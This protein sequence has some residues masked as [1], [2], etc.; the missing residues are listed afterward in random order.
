MT[1][2]DPLVREFGQALRALRQ[3]RGLSQEA[4]AAEAGMNRTYIS[5][6]ERGQYS[7]SLTAIAALAAA[8]GVKPHEL[9]KAAETT[10]EGPP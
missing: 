3:R 6:L 9:V 8:L 4:L 10:P 1:T 2:D 5:D 7:P